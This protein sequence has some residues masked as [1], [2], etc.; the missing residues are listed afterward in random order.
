MEKLSENGQLMAYKHH[1]FWQCMDTKRDHEYLERLENKRED[2][3]KM[4]NDVEIKVLT[5]I[6]DEKEELCTC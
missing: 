4:I 5:K 3:L 1:G 6:C 2:F